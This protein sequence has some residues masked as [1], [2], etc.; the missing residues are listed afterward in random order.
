[1]IVRGRLYLLT[2]LSFRKHKKAD[3]RA[4]IARVLIGVSHI[5][6]RSITEALC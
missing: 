3:A 5:R 4:T 6:Y 1:M 2:F